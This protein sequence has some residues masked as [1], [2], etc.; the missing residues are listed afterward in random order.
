M[1]PKKHHKVQSKKPIQRL[2]PRKKSIIARMMTMVRA[3]FGSLVDP[4]YGAKKR[5]QS[6]VHGLYD[7]APAGQ[8]K[9]HL[10]NSDVPTSF[11]GGG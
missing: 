10:A 11:G 3:F 7:D 9:T 2:S 6:N 8:T 1:P 5:R 4:N